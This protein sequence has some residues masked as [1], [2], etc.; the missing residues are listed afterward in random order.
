MSIIRKIAAASR[1]F[2]NDASG[3]V[4]VDWVAMTAAVVIVGMGIVYTVMGTSSSGVNGVVDGLN[5]E[6]NDA[7]SNIDGHVSDTTPAI[8]SDSE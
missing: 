6:I 8:L 3:A 2:S 5:T 1:R 7:A 4:T